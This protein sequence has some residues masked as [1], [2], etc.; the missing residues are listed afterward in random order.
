LQEDLQRWLRILRKNA[1]TT[2]NNTRRARDPG[3]LPQV[4]AL[5]KLPAT[6]PT[7]I[8][9]LIQQELTSVGYID[10]PT[11]TLGTPHQSVHSNTASQSAKKLYL[12]DTN[13][14]LAFYCLCAAIRGSGSGV[15]P[16]AVRQ[17]N[18]SLHANARKSTLF[19]LGRL[20]AALLMRY[21]SDETS[22]KLFRAYFNLILLMLDGEHTNRITLLL[23]KGQRGPMVNA[24]EER[25]QLDQTT[26]PRSPPPRD[27]PQT[28]Y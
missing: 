20:A 28:I 2:N 8:E 13:N 6:P 17:A 9:H 19:R 21:L 3:H 12:P 16:T 24:R 23:L 4:P 25:L 18:G 26:Y 7:L 15:S 11:T 22:P 10:P 27:K 1:R 5:R 14:H